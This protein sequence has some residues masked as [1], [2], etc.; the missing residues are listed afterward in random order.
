MKTSAVFTREQDGFRGYLY[1]AA[2]ETD[3]CMLV[4]LGDEGNDFLSTAFARWL[5]RTQG[6]YALCI[7]LR[8]DRSE[9]TGI[10]GW[11]LDRIE[12]AMEKMKA[13]G[14][15]KLGLL[16]MSMQGAMALTAASLIPGFS[17]VVAFTPCDFVPWGFYQ[18]RIGKE[19]HGEWPSGGSAF[20]W[21]GRELPFQPAGQ[22]KDAYWQMFCDAKKEF[23]EMHS[24]TIF[25][26]SEQQH[27]ISE[28]CFIPVENIGGRLVLIGTED[29]SMWASSRYIRRM[30]DRLA[31]FGKSADTL[32]YPFGT[33]LLTPDSLLK[34]ALPLVGGIVPR[35]FRSGKAHPKECTQAR[36]DVDKRLTRIFRQW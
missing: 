21:R 20:S 8:Q 29:D 15:K 16:G 25:E 3:R 33:H 12:T 23:K 17:L 4:V 28:D 7:A 18:G 19:A 9:D 30:E 10:H 22:E 6:C 1:P 32:V 2:A 14:M 5:T 26:F 31:R 35:M 34:L 36:L 13:L 27:P 24:R 11:P